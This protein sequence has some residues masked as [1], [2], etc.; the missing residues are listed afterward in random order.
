MKQYVLRNKKTITKE[1]MKSIL[2]WCKT[3]MGRSK[4][5]SIRKLRLRIDSR[6]KFLG[7]FDVHNNVIYVNPTTH[8][9]IVEIIETIIH[10][11]V[12]FLQNPK[13]YDRLCRNFYYDYYEHPHELEAETIALRLAKRCHKH[14]KNIS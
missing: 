11:Y 3:Y 4:Y 10:E 1:D 8:K 2:K 7:Q 14:L 5:F 12:H 9:N 6:M 13:E